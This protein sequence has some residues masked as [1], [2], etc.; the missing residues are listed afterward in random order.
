[1]IILHPEV[2]GP[3][4]APSERYRLTHGERWAL[5]VSFTISGFILFALPHFASS[6]L[7]DAW[8]TLIGWLRN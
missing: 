1:M 2:D 8:P 6:A 7:I 4:E 3:D 5:R